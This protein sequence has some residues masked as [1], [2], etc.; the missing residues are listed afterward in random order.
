MSEQIFVDRTTTWHAIGKD[1]QECK[2]MEQVLQKSGLDY[3]V[4]KQ[5][6]YTQVVEGGTLVEVP[7]RFMT[8]NSNGRIYDVVS[9][10][11]QLVQNREAFE[12]V[13]FMGDELSYEKAGETQNGMV[14]IIA[15]LPSVDILGDKFTP[16]VIFRNGFS[17]KIKITAAICPLRLVCQNQFN[18][19]FKGAQNTVSIRHV[20]NAEAKLQEARDVLKLSAD[21][22]QE[23]NKMA[24][25]YAGIKL[26]PAQVDRVL[27]QMFPIVDRESM[28]PFKLHQLEDAR[29][30]FRNAY[31]ADDNSNFR[32]TGW[33]LVNAYTDFITHKPAAGKAAT[34]AESKFMMV[35]FAPAAMNAILSA[36]QAVC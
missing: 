22:M 14:Y 7:N 36:I 1:V 12:F 29:T 10:K 25:Q 35:S 11:F 23:L 17:G 27:D 20:G 4:S 26:T 30:K 15:K 32:G 9:D 24:E 2:N 3:T 8:V 16:H 5:P 31:N 6:V 18:F 13:D 34:K 21:Y 19:A 28:N 33:G